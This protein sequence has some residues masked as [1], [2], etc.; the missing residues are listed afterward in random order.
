M[1][2]RRF[3]VTRSYVVILFLLAVGSAV[4]IIGQRSQLSSP[5][6][7]DIVVA[8]EDE[9]FSDPEM[10]AKS[11]HESTAVDVE[12]QYPTDAKPFPD[13][14][15]NSDIPSAKLD[16]D[17][18][19]AEFLFQV[20]SQDISSKKAKET[21]IKSGVNPVESVAGNKDTGERLQISFEEAGSLGFP[22]FLLNYQTGDRESFDRLIYGRR[23][24]PS[25]WTEEFKRMELELEE[26]FSPFSVSKRSSEFFSLWRLKDDKIVWIDGDHRGYGERSI[27]VGYEYE[28]H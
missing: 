7:N 16:S 22:V 19:I 13:S 12:K 5:D 27:I 17:A 25:I 26:K 2:S 23:P 18:F 8:G 4:W 14:N 3:M 1:R 21:L 15:Y 28:I 24:D 9:K 11:G 10:K 6:R 20:V